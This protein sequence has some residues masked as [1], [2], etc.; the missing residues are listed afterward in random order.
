MFDESMGFFDGGENNTSMFMEEGESKLL[1]E[2]EDSVTW[3][4]VMTFYAVR[5]HLQP[6]S[7]CRP[8]VPNAFISHI[9]DCIWVGYFFLPIMAHF[10]FFS[11]ND[12]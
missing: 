9:C 8:F 10:S 11:A 6:L 12:A 7:L 3:I 1:R 5:F 4:Y 2:R